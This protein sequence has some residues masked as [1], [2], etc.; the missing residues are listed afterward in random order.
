MPVAGTL[1]FHLGRTGWA[2]T[3]GALAFLAFAYLYHYLN[4]FSKAGFLGW[5]RIGGARAAGLT[6]AF[7]AFLA[8]YAWNFRWGFAAAT[9]L[10]LA[11][12]LLELPLDARTAANLI[13]SRS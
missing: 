13:S 6:A 8:L 11:H 7:A 1:V 4:W 5:H 12:V 3:S 2:A 10:G 9:W